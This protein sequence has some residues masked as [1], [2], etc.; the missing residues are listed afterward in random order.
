MTLHTFNK[1]PS[2]SQ[3]ISDCSLTVRKGDALLFIEDGVYNATTHSFNTSWQHL[4]DVLFLALEED[5]KARGIAD[6]ID[7]CVKL[8]DYA[9]FV[10]LCAEN[11]KVI[12]WY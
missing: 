12:S 9:Y 7:Q 3:L 4:D 5:I 11:D 6:D 2:N 10:R 1:Q 8:I